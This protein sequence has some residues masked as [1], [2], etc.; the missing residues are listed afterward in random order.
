ML[1][2]HSI[3]LVYFLIYYYII[4]NE[5]EALEAFHS[6]KNEAN[7]RFGDPRVYIEKYV[8]KARH[9]EI[10]LLADS[11]GNYISLLEREC[12]VR[13]GNQILVADSPSA[14]AKRRLRTI[15]SEQA[16]SIAKAVD[17]SSVGTAQFIIDEK[18]PSGLQYYF[19]KFTP[20]LQPEFLLSEAVNQVNIIKEMI[21]IAA[22]NPLSFSQDDLGE[23]RN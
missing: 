10:Q 16:L 14:F 23:V 4:R 3:L 1:H 12:S 9:I 2:F 21:N 15:L 22:G 13:H 11:Q 8:E 5:G 17:Y 6:I 20:R 18:D 7:A 19:T